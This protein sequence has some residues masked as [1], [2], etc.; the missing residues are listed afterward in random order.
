MSYVKSYAV[1]ILLL[2]SLTG[3]AQSFQFKTDSQREKN[4]NQNI[5]IKGFIIPIAL[6]SYG[7]LKPL[8]PQINNIDTTI[9]NNIYKNHSNFKTTADDYLM[10]LPTASIYAMD[11]LNIKT[12]HSF[13]EH[14]LIDAGSIIITGAFVFGMRTISKNMTVYNSYN[15]Q[16]PSG[17]AANAFRGAEMLHQELKLNNPVLSYSGYLVASGVGLLRLYNKDHLFTEVIA[18]AGVGLLSTKLTYL[19]FNRFKNHK[20]ILETSSLF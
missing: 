19:F 13:K 4:Y 17:H 6:I 5:K 1:I 15:T 18:G 20:S 14:L 11:A 8:I 12:R 3:F 7:S 9:R 2:L 10:W 16:F